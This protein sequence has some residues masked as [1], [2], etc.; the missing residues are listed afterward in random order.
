M[1]KVK[2]N[3]DV[4]LAISTNLYVGAMTSR[5]LFEEGKEDREFPLV[6]EHLAER[7]CDCA[8]TMNG[9][10]DLDKEDFMGILVGLRCCIELYCNNF[11]EIHD[12]LERKGYQIEDDNL[13]DS[14]Y[15][16][17]QRC[18]SK[19]VMLLD[20]VESQAPKKV[21]YSFLDY[22]RNVISD[23]INYASFCLDED[24]DELEKG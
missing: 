15:R 20:L 6:M 18:L 12:M 4:A 13:K 7:L 19:S 23:A 5:E 16:Q 11:D 17:L 3:K 1:T 8:E 22:K 24:D 21:I 10:I 14:R 2:F 9:R